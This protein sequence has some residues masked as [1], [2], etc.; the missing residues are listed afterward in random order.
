VVWDN[1]GRGRLATRNLAVVTQPEIRGVGGSGNSATLVITD[2][3]I[4][5][6]NDIDRCFDLR[7]NT[8]SVATTIVAVAT[9][10]NWLEQ[11]V[12]PPRERV[13]YRIRSY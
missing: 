2:L 1:G 4:T 12:G 9:A 10:T 7:S 8:W 3:A 11:W 5:S 6:S 13:F